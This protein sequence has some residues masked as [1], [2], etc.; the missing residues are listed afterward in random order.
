MPSASRCMEP[1]LQAHRGSTDCLVGSSAQFDHRPP[2]AQP[3]R[4][5]TRQYS[6]RAE[7]APSLIHR[8]MSGRLVSSS[9]LQQQAAWESVNLGSSTPSAAGGVPTLS[10]MNNVA[11]GQAP[12]LGHFSWAWDSKLPPKLSVKQEQ[13]PL[14]PQKPLIETPEKLQELEN[15]DTTPPKDLNPN[16]PHRRSAHHAFAAQAK[17]KE[18]KDP[19]PRITIDHKPTGYLP[20]RPE[21]SVQPQRKDYAA[22]SARQTGRA[23]VQTLELASELVSP[24]ELP[25]FAVVAKRYTRESARLS[26]DNLPASLRNA[27]MFVRNIP[28]LPF[29]SLTAGLTPLLPPARYNSLHRRTL[30]LDLDETLAHCKRNPASRVRPIAP[31]PEHLIVQFDDQPSY[32]LVGFR[33]FVHEFLE[34]ASK[35][36]EIVVFTASQK[37]YADKVIDVLDPHGTRIEHRLYREHCTEMRGAFFKELRLLGRPL[38]QC[39]LVDNSPISTACNLDNSILIRSWYEDEADQELCALS[40]LLQDMLHTGQES[41]E[42]L[43]KRYGLRQ[44]FQGLREGVGNKMA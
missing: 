21:S 26:L 34:A 5:A 40:E 29:T 1:G 28:V 2:T 19:D 33:P 6:S 20:V 11:H 16:M 31:T 8:P 7:G 10:F 9:G 36:F 27:L 22:N 35:D 39:I 43:S 15:D 23:V 44:F 18:N 4:H 12:F 38:H 17:G 41:S 32:G 14:T 25:E 3:L 13:G 37:S 24:E 42:Y 30:V